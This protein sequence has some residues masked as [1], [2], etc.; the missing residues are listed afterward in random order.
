[1]SS[2]W[3]PIWS[4]YFF[5][6]V[7]SFSEGIEY[8]GANSVLIF[9]KRFGLACFTV[10]GIRNAFVRLYQ[11]DMFKQHTCSKC[12]GDSLVRIGVRGIMKCSDCGSFVDVRNPNRRIRLLRWLPLPLKNSRSAMKAS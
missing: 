9:R 6:A 4:V 10:I 7:F 8:S 1:M 2:P 3:T 5:K 11:R 12:G